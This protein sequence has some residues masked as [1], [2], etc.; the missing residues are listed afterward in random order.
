MGEHVRELRGVRD[1]L[2]ELAEVRLETGIRSVVKV[3]GKK[4]S[5]LA[6]REK[7]RGEFRGE[8]FREEYFV[9]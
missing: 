6:G 8:G 4:K 5:L 9:F 3:E 1:E 7:L 2:S